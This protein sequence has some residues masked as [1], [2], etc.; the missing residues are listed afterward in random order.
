[1]PK[2]D[3]AIL[4]PN[5]EEIQTEESSSTEVD[6]TTGGMPLIASE[7]G[8]ESPAETP[9]PSLDIEERL[10]RYEQ[11]INRLKSSYQKKETELTKEK[12]ALEKKLED[13]LKASMSD[14]DKRLYE[15]ERLQEKLA[16]AESKLAELEYQ[17]A[18]FQQ[19]NTWQ[20]YFTGK[21]GIPVSELDFDNGLE[22]LF[23]SGM[24]AIEKK[25]LT[26]SQEKAKEAIAP[27]PKAKNPPETATPA[28]GKLPAYHSIQ[29]LADAFSE[30][31]VDKLFRMADRGRQDVI[32]LLNEL[33]KSQK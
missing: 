2:K 3:N 24:K 26:P 6:S 33:A 4:D 14:E 32:N 13:V 15:Q 17:T 8:A 31:D 9:A 1:M 21:F 18:Q 20:K 10:K 25:T 5:G 27:K 30:G 7:D 16:E 22:G 19:F 29:E 11:D 12:S 28:A 23:T